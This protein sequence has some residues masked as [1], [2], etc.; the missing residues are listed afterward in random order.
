MLHSVDA[1]PSKRL[2]VGYPKPELDAVAVHVDRSPGVVQAAASAAGYRVTKL[3]I[4]VPTATSVPWSL[5][6]CVTP[7]LPARN[8]DTMLCSVTPLVAGTWMADS[9][10]MS[11]D[12]LK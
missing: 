6:V 5:T 9:R 10:R 7:P 1:D 12:W 8:T 3:V 11:C 4:G 2:L